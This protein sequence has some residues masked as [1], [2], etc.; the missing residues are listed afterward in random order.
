MSAQIDCPICMDAIEISRNC[1]TTECGHC[2][3]ANC[4]MQSVAHNGFGCP[5]C[6]T[7]MAEVP[8]EED[9]D[10]GYSDEEATVFDE[11]AL[12]SFR[13]FHQ[14]LNGEEVEEEAEDWETDDEEDEEVEDEM[15]DAAYVA[16]KLAA[17]GITF[18]DLVKNILFQ[19]HSNYGNLYGDYERRSSEVYGQFRAVIT[20]YSPSEPETEVAEPEIVEPEIV[21]PEVFATQHIEV[22]FEAQPKLI[23]VSFIRE[24]SCC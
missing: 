21:E 6:R 8:A 24:T 23:K 15:P 1:V 9:S 18:E 20:Q 3:H 22:D 13:M 11:D 7:A 14:R 10:D 4:L 17:R 12:T 5:Y 16:Q 19:E 2:F